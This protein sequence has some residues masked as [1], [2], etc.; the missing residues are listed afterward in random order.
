V[1]V[2]R[3]LAWNKIATEIAEKVFTK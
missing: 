1:N 3:L 2:D